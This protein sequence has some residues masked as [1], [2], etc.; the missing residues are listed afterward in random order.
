MV[1]NEMKESDRGDPPPEPSPSNGGEPMSLWDTEPF[2]TFRAEPRRFWIGLPVVF[3]GGA[4]VGAM[5]G[6]S[7]LMVALVV[8]LVLQTGGFLWLY[9]PAL[10]RRTGE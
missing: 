5:V 6:R 2:A 8:Q 4:V 9:I 10:R 1:G 7:D 3:I